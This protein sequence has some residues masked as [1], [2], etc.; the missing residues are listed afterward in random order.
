MT[1]IDTPYRWRAARDGR[2]HAF[3]SERMRAACGANAVRERDAWPTR[4]RCWPCEQILGAD[5]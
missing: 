5:S 2:A 3:R 1:K 4:S